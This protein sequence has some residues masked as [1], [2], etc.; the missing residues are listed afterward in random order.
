MKLNQIN[1]QKNIPKLFH[2]PM[3]PHTPSIKKIIYNS[4]PS[5]Q[6]QQIK[7][8]QQ[9]DISLNTI[10][11]S[12]INEY[13]N[14]PLMTTKA[15][16]NDSIIKHRLVIIN[17]MKEF[18][19]LHHLSNNIIFTAIN[20]LDRLICSQLN[21]NIDEFGIGAL[22]LAIKFNE[23]E[24]RN[25]KVKRFQSFIDNHYFTINELLIVEVKVVKDLN[26]YLN[27]IHPYHF[28]QLIILN[29]IVF[30]IDKKASVNG[31]INS[32][33]NVFPFHILEIVMGNISYIDHHPLNLALSCVAL[34]RQI[35][36]ID[37]WNALLENLFNIRF[38]QFERE[39]SFVK[40]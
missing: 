21:I 26:Y 38:N 9:K 4:N 34:A 22:L 17:K 39:Y 36:Q 27:Y 40:M 2:I 33:I 7:C 18:I 16:V 29:G 32:N 6:F 10:L 30:N 24:I 1:D 23:L 25:P 12:M 5:F 35:Y 11:Q 13:C 31:V 19:H 3:L 8:I 20:Y 14:Y 37:K 15:N 28:L